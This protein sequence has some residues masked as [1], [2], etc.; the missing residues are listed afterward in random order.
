[1]EWE[2][3]WGSIGIDADAEAVCCGEER[4]EPKGKDFNFYRSIYVPTLPYGH[5][6]WVVTERMRLRI[7]AAKMSFL[8][9]V[10]GLN[11]R[12]WV[13]SSDFWERLRVE[14]LLPHVE[15]SQFRWSG[16]WV[17]MFLDVSLGRCLG[18]AHPGGC[19]GRPRT[20]WRDYISWLA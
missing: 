17:R 2:I 20:R 19:P 5:E 13:R 11:L 4:V 18:H 15:R 10:A 9:R 6:L 14:P 3:D 7:Q 8:C 1:M 16:H 12:D